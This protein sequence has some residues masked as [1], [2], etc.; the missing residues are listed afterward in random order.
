MGRWYCN[1][2]IDISPKSFYGPILAAKTG[3]PSKNLNSE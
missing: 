1:E 2:K 3:S